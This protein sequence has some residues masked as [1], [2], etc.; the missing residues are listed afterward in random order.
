M[1]RQVAVMKDPITPSMSIRFGFFFG[2]AD[3]FWRANQMECD[4]RALSH[5]RKKFVSVIRPASLLR[6]FN[7]H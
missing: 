3:I 4:F 2:Q 7:V 6:L 1:T 5:Q